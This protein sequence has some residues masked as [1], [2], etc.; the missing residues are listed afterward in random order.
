MIPESEIL[1]VCVTFSM[2]KINDGM[3]SLCSVCVFLVSPFQI[4]ALFV[5]E[6]VLAVE[7]FDWEVLFFYFN[8]LL[9]MIYDFDLIIIYEQNMFMRSLLCSDLERLLFAFMVSDDKK[10]NIIIFRRKG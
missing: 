7:F 4:F 5:M 8:F 1:F 6:F 3:K 2:K 9:F 10:Q